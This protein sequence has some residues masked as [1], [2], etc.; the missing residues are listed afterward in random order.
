MGLDLG[1]GVTAKIMTLTDL[2]SESA[3][4][5]THTR[6][7]LIFPAGRQ[8][9]IAYI[10]NVFSNEFCESLIR[11]CTENQHK[12]KQGLT[13][14]G[15]NLKFKVSQDW[16]LDHTQPEDNN[17]NF[18]YS[19]DKHIFETLW[20]V[21]DYYKG[22]FPSLMQPD[23]K[24]YCMVS[25]TGYQ[26]QQYKQN[27][28]FYNTHIDG[29]PWVRGA[30]LRVLGIIIYLNTVTHGGGTNFPFHQTTVDAVA[31]RV[32]LFPAYW[33]HPHEGLMPLSSDKWIVSTFINGVDPF[34]PEQ[35]TDDCGCGDDHN[36]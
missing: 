6:N 10:D 11:Y 33:T 1:T 2:V 31:G 23:S 35:H 22:T 4:R 15:V 28:G 25:D 20:E 14:G 3:K 9:G 21:V 19:L 24:E 34:A 17:D 30:S 7:S 16:N 29:S 32:A 13:M 5:Q 12:S 18:E 8:A 36:G 26:I 27:T